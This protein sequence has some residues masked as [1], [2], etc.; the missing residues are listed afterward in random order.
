MTAVMSC[1]GMIGV[2]SIFRFVDLHLANRG[3]AR[4]LVAI[5]GTT[6]TA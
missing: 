4:K 1:A 5:V 6:R 3:Y 2:R